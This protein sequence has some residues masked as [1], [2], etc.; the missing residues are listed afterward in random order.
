[1]IRQLPGTVKVPTDPVQGFQGKVVA[2]HPGEH[3]HV[4]RSRGATLFAITANMKPARIFANSG[5]EQ[6]FGP[7]I[8]NE[9]I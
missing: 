7:G 4:K 8:A 1:M 3:H 2:A 9:P 5:H 6:D